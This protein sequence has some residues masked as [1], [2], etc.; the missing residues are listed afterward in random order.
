MIMNCLKTTLQY[1]N[2]AI[3]TLYWFDRAQKQTFLAHEEDFLRALAL[4]ELAFSAHRVDFPFV[5]ALAELAFS[6]TNICSQ[7]F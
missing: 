6:L 7:Y 3:P 4:A 2:S 1:N 5:P